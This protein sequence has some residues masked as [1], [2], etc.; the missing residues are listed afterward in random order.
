MPGQTIAVDLH[1]KV[2]DEAV[3]S[4][5]KARGLDAVVYAPH[6]V[7]LPEIRA[8]A[9][10]F[11]DDELAIVPG[12]EVFTGTW[13]DRKHVLGIG[14][15]SPVPD[16]IDLGAAL[17][18]LEA[19]GA[20]VLVPHPEFLTVSLDRAD[21]EAHRD[22][23]HAGE[24]Y[25]AKGFG[26]FNRRARRTVEATGLP[27][28]GSSYAHLRGSVGAA[29]T[30]FP[31]VDPTESAIVEALREGAPRTVHHGHGIAY[32]VQQA[33]EFAHL[34]YENTLTKAS[35]FAAGPKATSPQHPAYG[36]AFDRAAVYPDW[37][38]Y[39]W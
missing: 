16:Y 21:I 19:Q 29:W 32:R 11:S 15:G 3:V 34:F 37:M 12:R 10:A 39:R 35:A 26:P 23:I 38:Y 33:A 30:A 20:A 18:A 24:V 31:D 17:D 36:G 4:R 27:P 13:R 25:N 22:S 8:R 2:L 7:R 28:F 5:A 1:V 6:F 14:L 9:A